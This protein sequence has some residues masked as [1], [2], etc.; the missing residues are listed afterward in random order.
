MELQKNI[1][2]VMSVKVVLRNNYRRHY[3]WTIHFK[4]I[5]VILSTN[6]NHQNSLTVWLEGLANCTADVF[7]LGFL[8][9]MQ[10]MYTKAV[11]QKPKVNEKKRQLS[12]VHHLSKQT[13]QLYSEMYPWDQ[14]LT[15]CGGKTNIFLSIIHSF[16]CLFV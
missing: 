14:T 1:G 10:R 8:R 15:S 11:A 4:H 16:V 5:I 12:V 9:A 6:R 3:L 13:L 7:V 2:G